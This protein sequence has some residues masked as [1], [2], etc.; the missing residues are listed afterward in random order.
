MH[1]A[2]HQQYDDTVATMNEKLKNINIRTYIK[3]KYF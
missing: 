2:Y 1:K 3:L